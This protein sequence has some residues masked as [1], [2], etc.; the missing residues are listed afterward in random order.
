MSLIS[1]ELR[2]PLNGI[3]GPL[4]LL[5]LD[6]LENNQKEFVNMAL[7]SANSLLNQLNRIL[8]FSSISAAFT[9]KENFFSS[10]E[11]EVYHRK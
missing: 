7:Q 4:Q 1:H 6:K 8:E 3:I 5:E 2:T 10:N 11:L 9:P